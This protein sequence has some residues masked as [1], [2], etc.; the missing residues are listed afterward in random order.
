MRNKIIATVSLTIAGILMMNG[1]A[2]GGPPP[3]FEQI[4]FQL[5]SDAEP[6]NTDEYATYVF[7]L[8]LEE[9]ETLTMDFYAEG[10]AVMLSAYTPS[11]VTIGYA[12]SDGKA[13]NIKDTG[14]GS[15]EERRIRAAAEGHFIYTVP[16]TGD[17]IFTVK[18]ASPQATIDVVID[19][20]IDAA[21]PAVE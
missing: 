15:L 16:E 6:G 8:Y 9:G 21:A 13:G 3:G 14:M 18:S 20:K 5:V 4:S 10:A 7:D 12:T 2:Q 19:Y 1:C 17:F 11:Q